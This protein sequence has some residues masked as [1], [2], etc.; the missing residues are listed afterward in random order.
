MSE[1]GNSWR[2]RLRPWIPRKVRR[3][4]QALFGWRWFRGR[5][6]NWSD[7]ARRATG[8]D[9]QAILARVLKATLEVKAG[10]AVYERDS[11][12]FFDSET[13]RELINRLLRAAK[14][15]QSSLRV[16]DFGGS[17][18]SIYWQHRRELSGISELRWDIVEQPHFVEAGRN[19]IQNERIRFYSTIDEAER[20]SKHDA[21]LASCVVQFLPDPHQ[22]LDDL[23]CR[24]PP[25]ILFHNLSLH[26]GDRDYLRIEYVP[27]EIYPASYPMW[28]FNR[29]KFLGHFAAAYQVEQAYQSRAVWSMGWKDYPSTGLIL[30]RKN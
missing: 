22:F 17:L 12:L 3:I 9:N 21:V 2:N 29:D 8:Y 28:F 26:D 6:T 11:V 16:L 19:Y 25:L 10:R 15:N 27:P 14:E 18:G 20:Q 4:N 5:Y 24:N 13:E 7:A 1:N 23:V 30:K